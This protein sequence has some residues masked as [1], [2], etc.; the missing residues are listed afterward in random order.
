MKKYTTN[1]IYGE[2]TLEDLIIKSIVK[3][4]LSIID[5]NKE[6]NY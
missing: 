5:Y 1:I 3:E 6:M 2:D 4:L